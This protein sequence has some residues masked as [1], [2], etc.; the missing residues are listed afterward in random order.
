MTTFNLCWSSNIVCWAKSA[1]IKGDPLSI[2]DD[3]FRAPTWADDLA[4]ACIEI[5]KKN[6]EGIYHIA[7]PETMSI[8]DI[9]QRIAKHYNY[10]KENLNKSNSTA[11]NQPAMRVSSQA[12]G[13]FTLSFL[14]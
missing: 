14:P 12:L 10:S 6:V 7:G 2:V 8:Y 13:L 11:L 1:L 4:W 3:Q 9:V 5:F